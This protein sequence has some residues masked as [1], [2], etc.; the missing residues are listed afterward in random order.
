MRAANQRVP[1]GRTNAGMAVRAGRI[2][3]PVHRKAGAIADQ[4]RPRRVS[5]I[6]H[7]RNQRTSGERGVVSPVPARTSP[8]PVLNRQR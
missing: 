8:R 1:R 2:G 7:A 6:L 3:V 4:S 5:R